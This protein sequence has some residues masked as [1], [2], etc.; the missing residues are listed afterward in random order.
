MTDYV[1]YNYRIFLMFWITVGLS[2]GA[3]LMSKNALDES[4]EE[5]FC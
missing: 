5:F 2:V 3:V 1:W 4:S